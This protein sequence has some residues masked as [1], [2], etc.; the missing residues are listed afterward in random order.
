MPSHWNPTLPNYSALGLREIIAGFVKLD[1]A[2]KL[3]LPDLLANI[4]FYAAWIIAF[5]ISFV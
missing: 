4:F 5:P 3:V 1:L 2:F